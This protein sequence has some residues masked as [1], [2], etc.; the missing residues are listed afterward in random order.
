MLK[1]QGI[2]KVDENLI[3]NP[4]EFL[5][6]DNRKGMTSVFEQKRHYEQEIEVLKRDLEVIETEE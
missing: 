3:R 2:M 1:D 6:T 5:L 4:K